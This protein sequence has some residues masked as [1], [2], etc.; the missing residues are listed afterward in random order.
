[1]TSILLTFSFIALDNDK[2]IETYV[3]NRFKREGERERKNGNKE[4][5]RINFDLKSQISKYFV[6]PNLLQFKR[7]HTCCSVFLCASAI[8][9]CECFSSKKG[10]TAKMKMTAKFF[11]A[12][13]SRNCNKF[14]V[15]WANG[16]G[17]FN[18]LMSG[19]LFNSNFFSNRA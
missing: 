3:S 17:K 19:C 1:M 10:K 16:N 6:A 9:T 8:S 12:K 4:C 18:T 2:A 15:E 14:D 11:S 7:T 13:I 5:V